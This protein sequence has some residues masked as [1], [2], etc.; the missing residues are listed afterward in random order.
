MVCWKR[1]KNF[2]KLEYCLGQLTSDQQVAVR[3][4]YLEDK[5]YNEVAEITGQ[6]WNQVRSFIQNG[7][8][9][10]KLCIEKRASENENY[11]FGGPDPAV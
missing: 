9:N 11:R 7:R 5:S 1:R 3:L 10:L 4:F 6:E 8:R 2:K